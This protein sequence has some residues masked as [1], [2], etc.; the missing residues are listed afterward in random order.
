MICKIFFVNKI[1]ID[2]KQQIKFQYMVMQQKR[3]VNKHHTC[4]NFINKSLTKLPRISSVVEI[5]N[6]TEQIQQNTY[7]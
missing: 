7:E 4:S 2:H 1:A 6:K 3:T 5:I